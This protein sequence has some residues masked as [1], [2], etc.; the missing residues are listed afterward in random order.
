MAGSSQTLSGGGA[1]GN[2]AL[3]VAA[4]VRFPRSARLCRPVQWCRSPTGR[5]LLAMPRRPAGYRWPPASHRHLRRQRQFASLGQLRDVTLTNVYFEQET[6][7]RSRAGGLRIGCSANVTMTGVNHFQRS[8]RQQH[9]EQWWA[10]RRVDSR[11]GQHH[12]DQHPH[13][14][15]PHLCGHHRRLRGVFTVPG[16][17]SSS[18]VAVQLAALAQSDGDRSGVKTTGLE[19]NEG[20]FR[21]ALMVP[22]AYLI[23]DGAFIGN[24]ANAIAAPACWTPPAITPLLCATATFSLNENNRQQWLDGCGQSAPAAAAIQSILLTTRLPATRRA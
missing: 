1:I 18:S 2:T 10:K 17:P 5:L 14:R 15:Q 4:A 20:R 9:G 13:H 12:H 7:R 21:C 8:R 16:A 6:S 19:R 3:Q 22:D 23:A 11:C 24:R